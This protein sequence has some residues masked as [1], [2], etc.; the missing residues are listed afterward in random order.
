MLTDLKDD[1]EGQPGS[2]D[3]PELQREFV[4]HWAPGRRPVVS[5]PA[6]Y[7]QAAVH[8]VPH[9]KHRQAAVHVASQTPEGGKE[10]LSDC[11]TLPD[12]P[13]AFTLFVVLTRSCG[14]VLCPH[15]GHIWRHKQSGGCSLKWWRWRR[16][17]WWLPTRRF[18]P[19][20]HARY[21]TAQPEEKKESETCM[22]SDTTLWSFCSTSLAK[23]LK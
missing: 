21:L 8:R 4:R 10:K 22:S 12:T 2:Q 1:D 20:S 7:G 23:P 15:T 18:L 14:G 17:W 3:V 11:N 16:R 6:V 5:V 13:Q 19:G 9:L